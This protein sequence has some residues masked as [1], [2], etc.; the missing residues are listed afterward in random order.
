MFFLYVIQHCLFIFVY[1]RRNYSIISASYQENK[2]DINVQNCTQSYKMKT[3]ISA[4]QEKQIRGH[5]WVEAYK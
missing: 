3:R 2:I 4:G 1:F 5:Y